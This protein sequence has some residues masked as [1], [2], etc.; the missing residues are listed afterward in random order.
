MPVFTS[1][2]SSWASESMVK[3][4]SLCIVKDRQCPQVTLKCSFQISLL[5]LGKICTFVVCV[6]VQGISSKFKVQ[7]SNASRGTLVFR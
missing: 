2:L 4:T 6:S 7:R 1:A 5:Y 3:N